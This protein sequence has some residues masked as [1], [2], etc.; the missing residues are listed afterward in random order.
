MLEDKIENK[1]SLLR[2]IGISIF[3]VAAMGSAGFGFYKALERQ[4]IENITITEVGDYRLS[5]QTDTTVVDELQ[6]TIMIDKH[7]KCL[8][9]A[10]TY[11][12]DG[13]K[14]SK[15]M[16]VK[17]ITYRY[18]FIGPCDYITDLVLK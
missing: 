12:R 1:P 3:A 16:K 18:G 6:T 14:P 8:R 10:G 5:Y 17:S 7:N 9:P 13:N 11:F 15:G 4:T 2:R